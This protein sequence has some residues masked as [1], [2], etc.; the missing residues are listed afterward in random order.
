MKMKRI[1]LIAFAVLCSKLQLFSQYSSSLVSRYK[2]YD[3]SSGKN[4]SV[5]D[6]NRKG[7]RVK[8]KYFAYRNGSSSVKQRFEEWRKGRQIIAY[9]SGTY[10]DNCDPSLAVPVGLCIDD[11]K[12]VNNTL[13]Y[14]LDAFCIVQATGGMVVSNLR[15]KDLSIVY[16]DNTKKNIDIRN[17][18]DRNVFNS[19]AKQV[20]ATV[21]QTHLLAYKN[22]LKIYSNGNSTTSVRRFLAVGKDANQNLHHIIISTLNDMSLYDAATTAYGYVT[23]NK[24]LNDVIYMINVD[25]G[26]QNVYRVYDEYGKIETKDGFSGDYPIDNAA[27]LIV[28]YYE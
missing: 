8:V 10:M 16:P 15:D 18:I 26:C 13:T 20:T 14:D 28:Y 4:V 21:F 17:T 9:S 5:L 12:L 19:W 1:F 22:Q 6:M 27:N 7:E 2:D 11:G 25:P 3:Y 23:R 24:L